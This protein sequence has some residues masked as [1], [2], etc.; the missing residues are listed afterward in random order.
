MKIKRVI[1]ILLILIVTVFALVLIFGDKYKGKDWGD[2]NVLTQKP[3]RRGPPVYNGKQ[4]PYDEYLHWINWG[5]EWFR[6][7][8]FGNERLW[9]D[10]IGVF[11][12]L[13]DVPAAAGASKSEPF[14]KYFLQAIDELDGVRGNLYT[15]NGQGYTNDLVVSLPPGSMLD[16]TIPIP[17]KLHTG[18]DVEAGSAWPLGVVPVRAPAEDENL[19]YLVDPAVYAGGTDGIGALPGGGKF[20]VGLSCAICHYS[21][22]IDWDGKPDLKWARLSQPTQGS[23]YKPQDAWAIGNQDIH[24]GWVFALARNTIAG[25]ETSGPINKTAVEDGRAFADWVKANY[26]DPKKYEEVKREVDRGLIVFPRGYADDTPDGLHDPLQF[27]SLFT[28]MNWPY[29]YD[30]VMVN[31][32]DRNNNVWT[33]G[34]DLSQLVALCNNRGG[35]SAKLAFWEAK[36][37]YTN[38]SAEDYADIVV[39]YS[40][41]GENNPAM[42]QKLR[43]DILGDSDGMPGM[44][45]NDSMV[46]I[47]GVPGAVPKNVFDNPDNQKFNRYREPK[48]FGVDGKERGPMTGLLGTRVISTPEIREK[49]KIKEL[50]GR[51]GLNGDEF[52]TEAVSMMLDWVEPPPNLSP[53]LANARQAGLVQKG[54]DLFKSEGCA[55]CHSGPYLTDNLIVRQ[56]DIGTDDA[57]EQAT[58]LI[59]SLLSPE[60]DPSTGLAVSGGVFGFISNL[61]GGKRPGYKSV[62]L[63]YLWGSAPYLHDGGVG[64][65]VRP[66]KMAGDDLQTLLRMPNEDKIYGMGQILAEREAHPET[67]LRPNAALS[68]QAI[69]LNQ[70]RT[71]VTDA[72]KTPSYPVPGSA[73]RL[74]MTS[75]RIQGV[76]HE[77]WLKDEP[78]GDK[79]TALVAFLLALDDDP[80]H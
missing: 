79:V 18:L 52:V 42:R 50:E 48:D 15:G 67:W 37:F 26:D 7:E 29:N 40:P 11:N 60:Y 41:A 39:R 38:L 77:F 30:G 5:E 45:R 32:S 10:V 1:Q 17:E 47:K 53:L 28:H 55:K 34:L 56:E 33:V 21:L 19:P 3:E 66:G 61:F 80:G 62:T 58:K 13:I 44:L 63:R 69:L 31:A 24:L 16:K 20:R 6:G 25:F 49:Y 2:Y 74:A 59:Q 35:A 12:G 71:R 4:V 22:D 64:V 73:E 14:M 72:N 43:D 46:L 75:M 76:G 9:T 51:Y 65:A 78:G 68:L 23:P 27:P 8:T 36:G 57:R 70:E 54:Y